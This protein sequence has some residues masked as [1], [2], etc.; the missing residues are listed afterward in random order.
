LARQTKKRRQEKARPDEKHP[1]PHPTKQFSDN[2]MDS[3][4]STGSPQFMGNRDIDF[5]QHIHIE[6]LGP[7]PI[8]VHPNLNDE[9]LI[10]IG[11]P[12]MRALFHSVKHSMKGY[13]L[14]TAGATILS[15]L[16]P[17][18]AFAHNPFPFGES[19]SLLELFSVVVVFMLAYFG[20]LLAIKSGETECPNCTSKFSYYE[21][22]RLLTNTQPLPGRVLTNY[23]VTKR[24]DECQHSE[25]HPDEDVEYDQPS[26]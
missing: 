6:K 16:F 26:N 1:E 10:R 4:N 18:Y 9:F 2:Q 15:L 20:P 21:R 17:Y 3:S 23:D 24:C 7:Q 5:E 19:Y 8:R 14:W 13:G 12:I 22:E 25:T 11:K